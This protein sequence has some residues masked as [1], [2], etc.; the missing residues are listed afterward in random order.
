MTIRQVEIT[1]R[2][3]QEELR[4]PDEVPEF[5]T[6]YPESNAHGDVDAC[7]IWASHVDQLCVENVRVTPRTWNTR[8]VFRFEDVRMKESG[9]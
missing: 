2:D 7:E 6:D 3:N 8:P 9:T 4:I 5:L 1:Y